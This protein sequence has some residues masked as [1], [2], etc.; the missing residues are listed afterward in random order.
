MANR[1]KDRL[2]FPGRRSESTLRHTF[3]RGGFDVS[4]DGRFLI[5]PPVQ[6]R[7]LTP[8]TVVVK[9]TAALKK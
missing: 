2:D 7:G 9:G 8:I 4:K 1:S 6:Q 5:P 3:R